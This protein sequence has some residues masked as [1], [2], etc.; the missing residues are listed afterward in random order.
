[1]DNFMIY[2]EAYLDMISLKA[3]NFKMHVEKDRILAE[4]GVLANILGFPFQGQHK[5]R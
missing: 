5:I 2:R 1:M 4:D 3:E